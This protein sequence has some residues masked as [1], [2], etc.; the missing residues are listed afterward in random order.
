MEAGSGGEGN[1]LGSGVAVWHV[2]FSNLIHKADGIMGMAIQT[3][4]FW[5]QMYKEDIIDRDHPWQ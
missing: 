1:H 3:G 2:V 5:Q 4:S